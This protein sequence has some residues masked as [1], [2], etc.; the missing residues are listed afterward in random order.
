VR[1]AIIRSAN[2]YNNPDTLMGYGIPN[3]GLAD[4]ILTTLG[5]D[6]E[7][8]ANEHISLVPNPFT[9]KLILSVSNAADGETVHFSLLNL[10]GQEL[11][12]QSLKLSGE[13]TP[14]DNIPQLPRGTYIAVLK[15]K[16]KVYHFKLIR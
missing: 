12:K 1:E 16:S 10:N 13:T 7:L 2:L 6:E 11:L 15:I 9:D 3:F 5:V 14:I 8:A 4:L